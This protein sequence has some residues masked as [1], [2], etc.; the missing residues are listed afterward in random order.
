MAPMNSQ[1]VVNDPSRGTTFFSALRQ[2]VQHASAL[3]IAVSYVQV[4]GWELIEQLIAKIKS[5]GIRLLITDQFAITHPEALRKALERGIQIRNYGGS[6]IYHPKVYLVYDADGRPKSA[7]VGSANISESGLNMG[8]EAGVVISDPYALEDLKNWFEQLFNDNK[9]TTA[10]DRESLKKFDRIW[11]L[12]ATKRFKI[13]QIARRRLPKAIKEIVPSPGEVQILEDLFS[14]IRLPIGILSIDHARNN[15]RNLKRLLEVLSRYPEIHSKERSELRLLGFVKENSLTE[16][17]NAARN[18]RTE[19]ALAETWCNWALHKEDSELEQI[20]PRI[21]SSKRAARQFWKLRQQV[22]EFFF[23]NLRSN[24]QRRVLQTIELLC[25]GSKVVR[26]LSLSDFVALSS[27]I[28]KVQQLPTFLQK[29]IHEYQSNKGS[30]SWDSDD[31][32]TM[33][34]AWQSMAKK[35]TK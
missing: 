1:F 6:R 16:L 30:R 25:N 18:C 32:K 19:R 7:I 11:H 15:V 34:I 3:D 27:V 21:V 26:Q 23:S 5:S 13:E 9:H 2:L 17:G 14:T 24:E 20:N 8:V 12:A 35:Q 31:R 4:S 10:I 33:L 22:R 29:P 28:M